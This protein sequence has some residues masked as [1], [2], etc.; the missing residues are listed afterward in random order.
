M[1]PVRRLAIGAVSRATR[2]RVAGGLVVAGL[3]VEIWSLFQDN[4]AGFM[5]FLGI[6][7]TLVALGVVLNIYWVALDLTRS[8]SVGGQ[9]SAGGSE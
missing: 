7:T 8:E 3:L 5:V 2:F 4:A 6:A 1:A 9:E